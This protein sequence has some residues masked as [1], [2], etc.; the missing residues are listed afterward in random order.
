[1]ARGAD[2]LTV[3]SNYGGGR[4]RAMARS[5]EPL[6]NTLGGL[7]LGSEVRTDLFSDPVKHSEISSHGTF[8]C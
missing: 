7:S 5:D 8:P 6:G 3:A 1:M 4:S 2:R